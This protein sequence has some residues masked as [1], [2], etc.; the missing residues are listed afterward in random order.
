MS[1]S[2]TPTSSA[3]ASADR[4][5]GSGK[6]LAR[7][8]TKR[9][10]TRPNGRV[11]SCCKDVRQVGLK[12]SLGFCSSKP[13]RS[14][15][16]GTLATNHPPLLFAKTA[17]H[18]SILVCVERKLQAILHARAGGAHLLGCFDL[19]NRDASSTYRKK[20]RWIGI[21]ARSIQAP[22][23]VAWVVLWHGQCHDPPNIGNSS[24]AV[25][26]PGDDRDG[27]STKNIPRVLFVPQGSIQAKLPA[28]SRGLRSPE[29]AVV[30]LQTL[31]KHILEADRSKAVRP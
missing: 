1:R 24:R 2:A 22:I 5:R 14:S 26:T 25:T 3:S 18:T 11:D 31:S 17:P 27:R 29:S 13:C 8:N 9:E 19:I 16:S 21:F 23:M 12:A 30:T 28:I 20:Q 4:F 6:P 15:S 7:T 10:S